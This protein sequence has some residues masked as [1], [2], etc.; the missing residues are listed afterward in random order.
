[1]RLITKNCLFGRILVWLQTIVLVQLF[2]FFEI[3]LDICW[4]IC[5]NLSLA[6]AYLQLYFSFSSCIM[7]ETSISDLILKFL[8]DTC[9]VTSRFNPE[10]N[11]N[12]EL[13]K[14]LA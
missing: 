11:S 13:P 8:K 3:F 5:I 12:I 6:P 9:L 1:M 14:L 10:K 2:S 7:S 4:D